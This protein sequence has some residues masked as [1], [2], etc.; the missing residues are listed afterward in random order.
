MCGHVTMEVVQL[1][2]INSNECHIESVVS[3][4]TITEFS[5]S[6]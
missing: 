2:R 5:P 1:T 6:I 4:G 3:G